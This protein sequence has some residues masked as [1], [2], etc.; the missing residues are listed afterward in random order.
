MGLCSLLFTPSEEQQSQL[1]CVA[2]GPAPWVAALESGNLPW[3]GSHGRLTINPIT[4]VLTT[5]CSD[6]QDYPI[7][8]AKQ[9]MGR[10]GGKL[11]RH[12]TQTVREKWQG[13]LPRFT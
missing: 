3:A 7:L 5:V 12:N 11:A 2:A 9:S 13:T 4:K 1:Q 8:V 10:G 6:W